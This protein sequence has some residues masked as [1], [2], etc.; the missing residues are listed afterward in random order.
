MKPITGKDIHEALTA[1]CA[2]VGI[3]P[4]HDI[5]ADGGWHYTDVEGDRQGRGAGRIKLFADGQGGHVANWKGEAL[6][7]FVDDGRKLTPDEKAERDRKRA[8]TIRQCQEEEAAK[9]AAAAVKAER[10]WKAATPA[11]ADHPYLTRKKV[12]PV[13]S[14]REIEADKL[15]RLLGYHPKSRGEHLTGRVLIVPVKAGGALTTCELIDEAGRKSAIAGG[16]KGGG[17]WAAQA[18]PEGDGNGATIMIGEGVATVLTAKEAT[19]HYSVAALCCGNLLAVAE[20]MKARFPAARLI[21]LA[22]LGNGQK[23]AEQAALA[24]GCL[25]AVPD[26]LIEEVAA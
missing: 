15:A 9:R 14:L 22:D 12:K 24:V 11:R 20:E 17:H 18:L 5:P 1:A 6:T 16:Q 21:V 10:T 25:L 23:D 7:F 19:G 3:V 13:P 8:E 2:V 4:R 26:F